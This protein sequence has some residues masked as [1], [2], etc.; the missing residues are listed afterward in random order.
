MKAN[1][2]LFRR[3]TVRDCALAHVA[4][5]EKAPA[6]G[7][8]TYIVSAPPPFRREDCAALK[9]DAAGVI[10]RYFPEAAAL[11]EAK[12]W[13]LPASIGRV[14][15]PSAIARDLGFRCR[16]DFASVLDALRENKA[17]PF[18]HDGDYVSPNQIA[19]DRA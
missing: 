13:R 3:L 16:D 18:V 14:Y 12:G 15:D 19:L 9:A 17:M 5:L 2:L 8:G 11:Y 10:A 1:E 7:F 6:I 4:A